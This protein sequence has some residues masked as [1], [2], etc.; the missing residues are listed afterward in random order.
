MAEHHHAA[1]EFAAALFDQAASDFRTRPAG[2]TW[3][4]LCVAMM[5][6]QQ[7]AQMEPLVV[8]NGLDNLIRDTMLDG[9]TYEDALN[10]WSNSSAN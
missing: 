4:P 10:F 1:R 3:E 8:A 2:N 5:R 6:L 7:A 9:K